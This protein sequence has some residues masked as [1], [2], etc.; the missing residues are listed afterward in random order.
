METIP[1]NLSNQEY[2]FEQVQEAH[3]AKKS[4]NLIPILL[5]AA[6]IGIGL[7]LLHREVFLPRYRDP[8]QY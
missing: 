2:F 3:Q 8:E 6:G 1:L 4:V 5:L 7:W